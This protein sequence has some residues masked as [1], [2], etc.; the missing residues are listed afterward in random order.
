[1]VLE[2]GLCYL[3]SSSSCNSSFN[4]GSSAVRRLLLAHCLLLV[5]IQSL[6]SAHCP[7][8]QPRSLQSLPCG[9]SAIRHPPDNLF[10][11]VGTLVG[12]GRRVRD[13]PRIWE[14]DW[15]HL[16]PVF[17]S[18]CLT[19]TVDATPFVASASTSFAQ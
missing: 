6:P 1:M 15:L 9:P 12:S 2:L 19:P 7:H 14:L 5:Q 4:S 3:S 17:T 18:R 10:S 16:P 8:L 11:R 13:P